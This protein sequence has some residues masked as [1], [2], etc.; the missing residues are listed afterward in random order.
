MT[1]NH[2]HQCN[3]FPVTCPNKC[4]E[5]PF[6]RQKVENHVKVECPLTEVNCPLHYAGCEVRLP[7]KDMPEHMRDTVTHLTLLATVTLTLLKENQ[8]LKQYNQQLAVK[9][10]TTEAHYQELQKATEKEFETFKKEIHKN[11][12]LRQIIKDLKEENH[13]IQQNQ[14][15]IKLK[16]ISTEKAIARQSQLLEATEKKVEMLKNKVCELSLT[17][18]GFPID[19]YVNYAIKGEQYSPSFYT[20]SHGYRM[21]M[22]VDTNGAGDAEGTHV[23]IYTCL[24][25]GTYD[26]HLKWPFRGEITIQIVNQAGDHSHDE[27]TIPYNDK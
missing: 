25:R 4:Q 13:K 17:F 6:E 2:H 9:Q 21:C 26:D 5:A 12:K 11:K 23:S 20:H 27:G 24:M 7:R 16:Q 19:F 10:S 8:E 18:G 3:K 15:Q 22:E 14:M 1:K